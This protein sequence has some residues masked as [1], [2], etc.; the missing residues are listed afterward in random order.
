M[1]R[2]VAPIETFARS[3][4]A[5]ISSIFIDIS[6]IFSVVLDFMR[7]HGIF[8]GLAGWAGWL[9]AAGQEEEEDDEEEEKEGR[10]RRR[11][12]RMEG[13]LTRLGGEGG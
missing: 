7:F 12:S 10:R 6:W 3:Q 1:K 11:R 8:M 4:L 13:R 2:L 5:A 9:L